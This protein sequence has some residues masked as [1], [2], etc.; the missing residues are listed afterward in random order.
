MRRLRCRRHTL[1]LSTVKPQRDAHSS[2]SC[3]SLSPAS[4]RLLRAV[5]HKCEQIMMKSLRVKKSIRSACDAECFKLGAQTCAMEWTAFVAQHEASLAAAA[6]A[7]A[8]GPSTT[9]SSSSRRGGNGGKSGKRRR[10]MRESTIF[11]VGGAAAVRVIFLFYSY[12]LTEFFTNEM[13][14]N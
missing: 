7:A 4:S 3:L 11:H 5:E 10:A 8:A 13:L 14:I 2:S 9:S 12:G 6:S 1:T